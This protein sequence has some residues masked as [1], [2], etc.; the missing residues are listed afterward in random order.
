M[1]TLKQKLAKIHALKNGAKTEGERCAAEAAEKRIREKIIAAGGNP[2][3]AARPKSKAS[4]GFAGFTSYSDFADF[5]RD[6]W[7]RRP[8]PAKRRRPARSTPCAYCHKPWRGQGHTRGPCCDRTWQPKAEPCRHCGKPFRSHLN[9]AG[10]CCDMSG[11]AA[12]P[13][14]AKASPKSGLGDYVR[15]CIAEGM[16]DLAALAAVRLRFEGCKTTIGCIRWY[17]NDMKKRGGI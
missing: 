14:R 9:A 1:E 15:Q 3:E 8:Q 16:S 11:A 2:D 4:N 12:E 7:S 13:K 5:M 6:F 17:R 10:P